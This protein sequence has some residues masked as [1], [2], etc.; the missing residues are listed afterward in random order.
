MGITTEFLYKIYPRP[1]TTPSLAFI[2]IEDLNDLENFEK[3]SKDPRYQI[4]IYLTYV[5]Q[6]VSIKVPGGALAF[7]IFPKILKKMSGKDVEPVIVQIVDMS[8]KAGRITNRRKA[9]NFLKEYGIKIAL[10]GLF[11]EILPN[12]AAL[13]DYEGMYLSKDTVSKRGFLSVATA[14]MVNFSTLK[15]FNKFIFNH[16]VLGLLNKDSKIAQKSGCEFCFMVIVSTRRNTSEEIPLKFTKG[17]QLEL[18]CLYP[19]NVPSK[20]PKILKNLK[21]NFWTSSIRQGDVPRQYLN[22]PSCDKFSSYKEKYFAN[23]AYEKLLNTKL[24]W[25]PGNVFNHCQSIGNENE[26]CCPK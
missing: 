10:D 3:A 24:F 15:I 19:K 16:P 5:F 9:Y 4:S 23:G 12:S 26:D 8:P 18:T 2:F 6:N 1:E 22:T 11:A 17:Y 14:N 21:E 7:K 20:C 13:D 25:D